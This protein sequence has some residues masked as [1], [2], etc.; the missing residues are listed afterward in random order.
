MTGLWTD[1]SVLPSL[2]LGLCDSDSVLVE[3]SRGKSEAIVLDSRASAA[4]AQKSVATL[5]LGQKN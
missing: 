3:P 4:G 5:I 2:A 1:L